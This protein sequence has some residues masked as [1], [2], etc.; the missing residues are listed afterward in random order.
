MHYSA[1]GNLLGS[2]QWIKTRHSSTLISVKPLKLV[3]D[4]SSKFLKW[5]S[6]NFHT[7]S[8]I[9]VRN[10]RIPIP[11]SVGVLNFI[12]IFFPQDTEGPQ[13]LSLLCG[14]FCSSKPKRAL[15]PEIQVQIS[16]LLR[17]RLLSSPF[18][19]VLGRKTANVGMLQTDAWWGE[20]ILER[21]VGALPIKCWCPSHLL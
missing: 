18:P 17:S 1:H 21:A 12:S 15:N 2:N 8:A 13:G 11:G 7:V 16:S 5:W 4:D 3:S 10:L 6:R 9:S 19:D 20:R 14:C